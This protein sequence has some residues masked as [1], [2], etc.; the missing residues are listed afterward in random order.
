MESTSTYMWRKGADQIVHF[1]GSLTP[2][3]DLFLIL[4]FSSVSS[5]KAVLLAQSERF[6]LELFENLYYSLSPKFGE[7]ERKLTASHFGWDGSMVLEG[8]GAGIEAFVHTHD[9][10]ASLSLSSHDCALCGS[11]ATVARQE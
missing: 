10:D 11:G 8:Y 9:R 5:S 4:E 6:F 7:D 1:F 3:Y 2:L